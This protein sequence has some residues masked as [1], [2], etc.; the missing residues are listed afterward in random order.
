MCSLKGKG[1]GAPSPAPG[2]AQHWEGGGVAATSLP[3]PQRLVWFGRI[4]KISEIPQAGLPERGAV[5]AASPKQGL[6]GG[7]LVR[8]S[9]PPGWWG[10]ERSLQQGGWLGWPWQQGLPHIL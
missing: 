10:T 9:L 2:I 4:N 8:V 5:E 6:R 1:R 3:P 7:R